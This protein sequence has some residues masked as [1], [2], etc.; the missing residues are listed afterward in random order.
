METGQEVYVTEIAKLFPPQGRWTEDEYFAL[1][2]ANRIIELSDG[3][4][5]MSPPPTF[6]HQRAVGELF[7]ALKQHVDAGD[8]GTAA[9]AP[10]AIRL[11]EGKIRE[12]DVM[13]FSRAHRD[14][15]GGE[16]SGPPDWVA[17]VISPGTK[18]TDEVEKLAEYAQA[19]IAEYWLVDPGERTIRV[20]V[21]HGEAAYTLAACYTAG[22]VARAETVEGFAVAVDKVV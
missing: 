4:L 11:W 14:R 18:K 19:G 9:V 8:L 10:L 17:E 6:E 2:D 3:E 16:V 7:Y 12:P 15:I 21:L 13:F 1:P 20:Y 22:Q 5:I